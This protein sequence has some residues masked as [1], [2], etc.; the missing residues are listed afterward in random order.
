MICQNEDLFPTRAELDDLF[1]VF[2]ATYTSLPDREVEN[3]EARK[4]FST[5]THP[6]GPESYRTSPCRGYW[7]LQRTPWG[8]ALCHLRRGDEICILA[9]ARLPLILHKAPEGEYDLICEAYLH[10][11]M[12]GGYFASD[13]HL[14][15][16]VVF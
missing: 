3:K 4:I 7:S 1:R 10:G 15:L 16:V 13:G 2:C 14:N 8:S 9:G 5:P 6:I 12:H 11:F